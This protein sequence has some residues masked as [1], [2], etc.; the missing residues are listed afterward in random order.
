MSSIST[1]NQAFGHPGIEPKWTSAR[2]DA[3]GTA[4]S[5]A[6]RLWF[7]I[8]RGILT[9]LYYPTIDRPQVRDL[10]FL[11]SDG[12]TFFHEE[13]RDMSSS[14]SCLSHSL[15][16]QITSESRE[17]GYKISKTVIADPHCASLLIHVNWQS[18]RPL[19]LYVL[20]S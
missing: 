9:E 1:I 15:G 19:K 12:E 6:S 11:V 14:L 10:Q 8:W 2:K 20:C 4:Y 16:Y 5:A 18:Q 17:Q 7:T 3:I 13:K